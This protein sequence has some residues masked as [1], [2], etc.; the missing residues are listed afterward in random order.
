MESW[1]ERVGTEP[2]VSFDAGAAGGAAVVYNVYVIAIQLN[3]ISHYMRLSMY[4]Y[5]TG[6]KQYITTY[7]YIERTPICRQ[8]NSRKYIYKY[9]Y[10]Y[11][12]RIT[13]KEEFK[14]ANNT[15]GKE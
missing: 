6:T 5:C 14:D 10:V 11:T 2:D 3:P 12:Y 9:I 8:Q 13:S 4:L 15:G 7:A 1:I